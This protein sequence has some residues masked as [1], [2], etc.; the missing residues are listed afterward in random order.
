MRRSSIGSGVVGIGIANGALASAGQAGA[1]DGR[2]GEVAI[3]LGQLTLDDV[4]GRGASGEVYRARHH[5]RDGVTEVAVKVMTAARAR[6][7]RYREAFAAEVRAVAGLSHPGVVRVLDLGEVDRGAEAASSGSLVAG[8]PYLA[9]ELATG[10]LRNQP[11]PARWGELRQRLLELLAALAHAHAHGVIHRDVKPGN[12]LVSDDG[13]LRLSD[14][15]L[16]HAIDQGLGVISGGGGTPTF[17]APEQFR[18]R[19]RVFGPWTDLYALGGLA[20]ALCTGRAPYR[21]RRVHELRAAHASGLLP[22]LQ[23]RFAVP[24]GLEDWLRRLLQVDPRWRFQRAADAA[25]AL[26]QLGSA[27]PAFVRGLDEPTDEIELPL[28]TPSDSGATATATSATPPPAPGRARGGAPSPQPPPSLPPRVLPPLPEAPDDPEP[29][30]VGRLLGLGLGLYGLR[31]VPLVGRREPRQVLW[32]QLRAV[33]SKQGLGVAILRGAAGVGKTRLAWWLATQAHAAGSAEVLPVRHL[34]DGGP[35]HGLGRTIAMA[36]A[37]LGL[38]REALRAHLAAWL[39][40]RGSTDPWLCTALLDMVWPQSSADGSSRFASPAE[41]YAALRSF[42]SLLGG[43]LDEGRRPV[44]LLVDDAQWGPDT[45]GFVRYL[46]AHPDGDL[47]LMVV[48]TVRDEALEDR[49]GEAAQLDMLASLPAAATVQL[50]V[51]DAAERH[52]LAR[53]LLGLDEALVAQVEERTAGHPLF[54]VQLVGDWVQRGVLEAAT[55]GFVL[56]RGER[57]ELPDDIH[58]LW[59]ARIA[60]VLEGRGAGAR[61]ALEL[62]A[63]LGSEVDRVEWR[64]ACRIARV[65]V[66]DGLMPDLFQRRL[67]SPRRGGWAFAHGMLRE[68]LLRSAQEA[69]RTVSLHDAAATALQLRFDVARA[70]GLAERLGRHLLGAQRWDEAVEPLSTGA[71]ERRVLSDYAGAVHLSELVVE[72]M[73]RSGAPADDPRRVAED[74]HRAELWLAT[75]E[76][77]KAEAL[78]MRVSAA[79]DHPDALTLRPLALRVGGLAA[80]KQGRL[81][82]AEERL[83]AAAEGA[84]ALGD[85]REE[86]RAE[87]SLGEVHRV[88]G[89]G[90]EA[91]WYGER[92]LAAF[93]TLEDDRGCADAHIGLAAAAALR[94]DGDAEQHH[95]EQALALYRACGARFGVAAAENALGDVRRRDG[96]LGPAAEAYERAHDALRELG[97]V[98]RMVPLLN[99]GLMRLRAEGPEAAREALVGAA[100]LAV[101]HGRRALVGMTRVALLPLHASAGDRDRFA[102]DL[103]RG[104][105]ALDTSGVVDADI[106]QVARKAASLAESRG[107]AL[108]A[109]QARD[110]ANR[111]DPG[112]AD[113]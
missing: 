58:Q 66:D 85:G 88:R 19:W 92:A 84:R 73:D 26:R 52:E 37:G 41:R 94:G 91:R 30:Q 16:A 110:L 60:R 54:A 68:S 90:A 13:S 2:G 22:R 55:T 59:A 18:G 74:A 48:L 112:G 15:G 31:E 77:E 70:P 75:G 29:A 12:V 36:V 107:W 101:A 8:S 104:A 87:Q 78:A 81:D 46:A 57:A 11:R 7:P 10:S 28:P 64:G 71:R 72:A 4:V 33:R 89:R 38:D 39:S 20:W 106:A 44:I 98:D 80:A 9:M 35:S 102:D 32:S 69:E 93:R 63:L 6:V 51:L 62:A 47:P 103:A 49:P 105:E 56:R 76:L 53:Q 27:D 42:L 83:G 97:S 95:V 99:L 1:Y 50:D 45:L 24:P 40:R 14:F 5:G 113:G 65:P 109:Q 3:R 82:A 25:A 108:L 21:G 67:A 79:S 61:A 96:Q 111:Q 23:P 34:P 17:M 86:A 100:E 43:G